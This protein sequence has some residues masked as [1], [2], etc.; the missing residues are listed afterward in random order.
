MQRRDASRRVAACAASVHIIVTLLNDTTESNS[1]EVL[2][3]EFL[4]FTSVGKRVKGALSSVP[5]ISLESRTIIR[6]MYG[7]RQRNKT[8]EGRFVRQ[9]RVNY[10]RH[11]TMH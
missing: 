1:P 10:A 9:V 3:L 4:R 11:A 6:M 5:T 7:L 2:S 8:K